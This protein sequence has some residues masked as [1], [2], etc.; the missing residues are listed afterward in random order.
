ME[1]DACTFTLS[2]DCGPLSAFTEILYRLLES[3]HP[4]FS[5]GDLPDELIRLECDPGSAGAKEGREAIQAMVNLLYCA[6]HQRK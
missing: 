4:A 6:E 3:V 1:A 5:L 2:A